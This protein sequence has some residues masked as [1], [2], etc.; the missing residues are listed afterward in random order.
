M[1][2]N[3]EYKNAIFIS[4]PIVN[5]RASKNILSFFRYYGIRRQPQKCV[6]FAQLGGTKKGYAQEAIGYPVFNIPEICTWTRELQKEYLDNNQL[7]HACLLEDDE[8]E[9]IKELNKRNVYEDEELSYSVLAEMYWYY[10]NIF[11]ILQPSRVII[12]GCW[13]RQGYILAELAQ[14][15]K[16][17][18]GFVEYG[19][20]PG[21]IQF[22][23]RGIAGQSEY[24][25]NPDKLLKLK[26]RD[27]G[28]NI[29]EIRKYII[30]N[31]LDTGQFRKSED[32]EKEIKR[33]DRG[34]KTVFLAGMGEYLMGINPQS[35]YWTKYVS[36]V[37]S[38]SKEAALFI[39]D[40]CKN[41]DWN[42]VFKP[43]P[44]SANRNGLNKDEM[45]DNIIQIKY[46]EIG[47]LIQLADVVVSISSKVDYTTLIYGKPLVQLGHTTLAGKGCAYEVKRINE[48]ESQLEKALKEGMTQEQNRNFE[49]HMVQLLENYLWDDLSA[50]EM[51]YGLSLETDFFDSK[52]SSNL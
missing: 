33:I 13:N 22:G 26:V 29:E 4:A 18:H 6:L 42:F 19:W 7:V 21:T 50:R 24:A 11:A 9:W 51:R 36:S 15:N 46:M 44:D 25:V 28:I 14:R 35:D 43:H 3:N 5:A 41:N 32:D 23:R 8:A 39:A 40:I 38:S 48:V 17:Q 47:R 31:K 12:W 49:L 30:I 1:E 16:I 52:L 27:K 20:V 34:K 10:K 37:V 45:R 2:K